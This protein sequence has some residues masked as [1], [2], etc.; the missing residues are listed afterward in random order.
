[1]KKLYAILLIMIINS[2]ISAAEQSETE[3]NKIN[4]R[5]IDSRKGFFVG[6]VR[7]QMIR[8]K[9]LPSRSRPSISQIFVKAHNQCNRFN[10]FFKNLSLAISSKD[11]IEEY[12]LLTGCP[13]KLIHDLKIIVN[14]FFESKDLKKALELIEYSHKDNL[15]SLS[16]SFPLLGAMV[17]TNE[18]GY[19]DIP[20]AAGLTSHKVQENFYKQLNKFLQN[21]EEKDFQLAKIF[22]KETI[23]YIFNNLNN[24]NSK[25]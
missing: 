2:T 9:I 4:Q 5:E 8:R 11:N 10:S 1:M 22:K 6:A 19:K 12:L 17:S 24:Q 13:N 20:I 18:L 7:Y 21:N 3:Q 23:A 14:I 25:K 15:H 16:F